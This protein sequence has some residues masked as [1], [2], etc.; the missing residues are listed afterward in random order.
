MAQSPNYY[1]IKRYFPPEQWEIADCISRRECSPDR[2][3]YPESCVGDEGWINCGHGPV[4]AHSWGI[5]QILDACWNPDMNPNSPFTAEH[6]AQ[7]LDPNVNTWMAS[8]I[9]E[10]SG[11]RAWTTCDFCDACDIVGGPIPYPRGPVYDDDGPVIPTPGAG[12]GVAPAFLGI[13]LVG[14]SAALI[15]WNKEEPYV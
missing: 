2:Q 5:F 4:A 8:I 9:W 1:L 3:G 7:V 10:R 6:W 14:I 15:L 11:W 12:L 13:S